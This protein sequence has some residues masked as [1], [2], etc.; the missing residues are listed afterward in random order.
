VT[1]EYAHALRGFAATMTAADAKALSADPAVVYVAQDARAHANYGQYLPASWGLNRIDQR[2]PQLDDYYM[3][4]EFGANAN[5]YVIDSGIRRDHVD[6]LNRVGYTEDF[7]RDGN[8]GNDCDGHGTHVSGTVGGNKS[9]VAKGVRLHSLRVL[10]CAGQ[11]QWSWVIAA[12]DWVI[13]NGLRPA[14]VN[15][16]LGG[17]GYE[18]VDT[19]V[20]RVIASGF[21]VVVAAGNSNADACLQSPARVTEA[22]TVGATD[23]NDRRANFSNIGTCVDIFAPGVDIVSVAH[24]S[25]AAY[26]T[27][28]GTS[29]ASPHVAGM[30]ARILGRD[31]SLTPSQVL[32]E[33][34]WTA[35]AGVIPNAG[36]GSMNLLLWG[37]G[38]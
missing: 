16:S 3:Y 30:A 1:H 35:T 13:A 38:A 5:A 6:F 10:G 27:K 19:A 23:R 37:P 14:V 33:L 34:A 9:G 4:R 15:I 36:A 17:L 12:L 22:I 7:V 28:S 11:G 21:T 2:T 8:G 24:T 25:R 32:A 20:R 31:P 18:P 29:M 26:A